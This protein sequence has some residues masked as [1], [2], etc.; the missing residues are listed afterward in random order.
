MRSLTAFSETLRRPLIRNLLF[1]FAT[2]LLGFFSFFSYYR[3]K[4]MIDSSNKVN[5]TNLVIL[6]IEEVLSIAKDAETAERG[7]LITSDS[8]FLQ[9]SIGAPD[10][11]NRVLAQL[12][13]LVAD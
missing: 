2:V 4:K 12:R 7:F 13:S 10:R 3:I 1:I 5:H 6:K 9:P 8:A 11:A